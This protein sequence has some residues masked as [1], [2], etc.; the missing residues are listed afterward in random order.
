MK[1]RLLPIL[2]AMLA[3]AFYAINIPFSKLL[4]REIPP[5]LMAGFLYLGAGIGVGIMF[6]LTAKKTP[7]DELLGRSDLPYVIGMILLDIIAPILLMFG[8]RGTTSANASLLNNF[9]IV[10]TS[11]IALF[12]FKETI[13]KKLWVAISMIT[14]SGALLTFD[15]SSLQF[16]WQSLFIIGA[17]LCWGFENN[18]TKKISAKSSYEIVT[19]D[20]LCCGIGSIIVGVIIGE[21]VSASVYLPL[22]LAL[23]FVA[24]GLS[25]LFYVKAQNVLGAAKTSA[26]YAINPFIGVILSFIVFREIPG[27]N[28]Y[29]ALAIMIIATAFV[30]VDTLES[31]HTHMHIHTITHT[32]G[33]S[34]HT[35]KI[36]HSHPHG[37]FG[38]ENTHRHKHFKFR[39]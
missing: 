37:H 12:I 17:A 20:G 1:K 24:Y 32:R 25:V 14:V 18:F 7:K 2:F 29:V 4:L 27:W 21:R 26:F 10:A 6:L 16:S 5:T 15:V 13:S 22:S 3:A 28:F 9:E 30:I 8:I 34:T 36:E 31:R 11:L 39:F 35:H 33:G 19:V 38:D 23:G